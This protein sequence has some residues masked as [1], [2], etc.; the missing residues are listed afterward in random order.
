MPWMRANVR[1]SRDGFGNC[2]MG[3]RFFKIRSQAP[4]SERI[5]FSEWGI[6]TV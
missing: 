3:M 4:Q 2:F 6:S 1:S 5:P